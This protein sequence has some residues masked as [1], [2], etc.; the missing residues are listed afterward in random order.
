MEL[1]PHVIWAATIVF[2]ILWLSK[3]ANHTKVAEEAQNVSEALKS[4]QEKNAALE[5]RLDA[6]EAKTSALT[7]RK[8]FTP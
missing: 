7:L 2:S 8:A 6:Q 1:I 3:L 5:R 4:I